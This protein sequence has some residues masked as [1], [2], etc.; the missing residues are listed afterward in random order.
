MDWNTTNI[1]DLTL[2]EIIQELL[3]R[4]ITHKEIEQISLMPNVSYR[5]MITINDLI[6]YLRS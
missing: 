5:A 2:P 4:G 6:S 3:K 1:R